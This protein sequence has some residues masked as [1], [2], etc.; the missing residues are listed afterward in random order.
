MLQPGR[1]YQNGSEPYRFSINGQEKSDELNLNMTT[2]KFW[3]YDSRIGRRWNVEP[4]ISTFPYLSGYA[5]FN[6][7]PINAV[8]PDGKRFYFVGG[9]ANDQDGWHYIDRFKSIFNK[10]GI[11]DFVRINATGGKS[12]DIAFTLSYANYGGYYG[13]K[14]Y[15]DK[16]GRTIIEL[17]RREHKQITKAVNDI[18]SD[19]T[20]HPLKDGEQLNLSGYSYGSVLQAQVALRLADK[21]YKV[22]NLVLIGSPIS[23]KSSLYKELINNPNIKNVIRNDIPGDKFSNPQSQTDLL[24]GMKQ[25]AAKSVGGKGDNAPHFDLARP[26]AATDKRIEDLGNKLKKAGVH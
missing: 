13:E 24:T 14:T 22:D 1:S 5:T 26:G 2:A 23:D 15:V 9:A 19:L 3:E 20:R 25:T 16:N 6:N 17:T 4:L 11:K 21:G 8:D 18:I 10:V 7:S 12:N